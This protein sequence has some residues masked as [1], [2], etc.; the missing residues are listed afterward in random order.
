MSAC[1][2]L[3]RSINWRIS[4]AS[5]PCTGTGKNKSISVGS[6][7]SAADAPKAALAGI[8]SAP[9]RAARRVIGCIAVPLI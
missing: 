4:V 7:A 5:G 3:K 2:L 1:S 6:A 8:A 9:L